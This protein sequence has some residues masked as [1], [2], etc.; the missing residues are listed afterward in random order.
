MR[1]RRAGGWTLLEL[2]VALGIVAVLASAAL[3]LYG[4]YVERASLAQLLLQ[5]DQIAT[6]VHIEDATGV[7]A[8]QRDAR[9]GKAPQALRTVPD[10]AFSERGG[11][12]LL[13][14]RA[15][16]GFFPSS[17]ASERYALVATMAGGDGSRRLG[18][19]SRALPFGRAD[20]VWLAPD[21]LAF[22]LVAGTGAPCPQ[23]TARC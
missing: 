1:L 23:G 8:L 7:R 20:Q 10:A 14:I 22:P 16:A 4:S 5:V 21:K 12:T 6:A 11:I 17:A 2:V 19:L 13:L 18:E 9:P 15:P 3:P